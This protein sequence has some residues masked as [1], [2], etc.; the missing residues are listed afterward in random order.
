M[1]ALHVPPRPRAASPA[2]NV[3]IALHT[4]QQR[5]L[6]AETSLDPDRM[7]GAWALGWADLEHAAHLLAEALTELDDVNWS[8]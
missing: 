5:I 8:D 1:T 4:V 3:R 2:E 6:A 7:F